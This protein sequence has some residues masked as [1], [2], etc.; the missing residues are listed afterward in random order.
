MLLLQ[1]VD[2]RPADEQQIH[3]RRAEGV[4]QAGEHAHRETF[5]ERDA[6]RVRVDSRLRER[7][8]ERGDD[9]Q[10][11]RHDQQEMRFLLERQRFGHV[12]QHAV[13]QLV[14]GY[15]DERGQQMNRTAAQRRQSARAG[16]FLTRCRCGR[17][18]VGRSVKTANGLRK[19]L[20]REATMKRGFGARFSSDPRRHR[21]KIIRM[22]KYN[23]WSDEAS[24][25]PTQTARARSMRW[26]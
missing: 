20:A 12:E 5:G 10:Q 7:R 23:R 17:R 22:P 26:R 21:I 9:E 24:I 25:V 8:A 3:F 18:H 6:G 14:D 2:A 15:R 19:K 11:Q 1:L 4:G 16:P 13:P